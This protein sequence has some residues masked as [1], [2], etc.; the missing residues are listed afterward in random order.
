[1]NRIANQFR[2]EPVEVKSMEDVRR[3]LTN[4]REQFEDLYEKLGQ[5]KVIGGSG[6]FGGIDDYTDI[7]SNGDIIQNGTGRIIESAKWKRTAI[8]GMA[9]KL[10]NKT[11][12]ASVAGELVETSTVTS[13]AVSQSGA[14]SSITVGVF[15]DDGIADGSE[16]WIVVAG[17]ADVKYDATGADKGDWVKA[18]GTAGRAES[19]GSEVPGANHFREIGHA[20]EDAAANALGRIVMHFN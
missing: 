19:S 7:L 4:W 10:T 8:G 6:R 17:I 3:L 9:I 11:G 13:D 15:L 20:L 12:G 5:G 14:D 2:G 1:M 16:A 18:S